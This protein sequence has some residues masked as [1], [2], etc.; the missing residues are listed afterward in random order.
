[1]MLTINEIQEK[2]WSLG[3]KINAPK[4][5]LIVYS[6][7]VGDGSAYIIIDNNQYHIVYSERGYEIFRQ[8]TEDLN[9]LLYWIM[10]NVASQMASEYE[11][12]NRND[13]SKDFRRAY[14]EKEL[15]ILGV[16]DKR[17]ELRAKKKIEEILER[18]PY[19]DNSG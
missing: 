6:G 15:E 19:I 1:M 4:S 17:W 8:T 11:L 3:A 18:S 5:M 7:P 13:E 12:K 10:E 2:V 16:L 14:F 9:E